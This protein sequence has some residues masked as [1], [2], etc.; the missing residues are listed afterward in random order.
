MRRALKI[1]KISIE[2]KK[3]CFRCSPKV[4]FER[5]AAAAETAAVSAVLEEVKGIAIIIINTIIIT[6]I[7]M[8]L[9]VKG[10]TESLAIP[11]KEDK[12]EEETVIEDEEEEEEE[13]EGGEEKEVRNGSDATTIILS[14][15][16]LR[17]MLEPEPLLVSNGGHRV[18]RVE[19]SAPRKE[20]EKEKEEGG[21]G[22]FVRGVEGVQTLV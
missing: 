20:E 11:A 17:A 5:R 16:S 13:E 6:I 2:N 14:A 18:A 10:I 4:W 19:P 22:Y 8:I 15:N 7:I 12:V 3:C 21:R 9:Q 1:E